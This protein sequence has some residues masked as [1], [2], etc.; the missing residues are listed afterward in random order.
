MERKRRRIASLGMHSR[1]RLKQQIIIHEIYAVYVTERPFP[2][3]RKNKKLSA[4]G[5]S[6]DQPRAVRRAQSKLGLQPLVFHTMTP[7][8]SHYHALCEEAKR[9][10]QWLSDNEKEIELKKSRLAQLQD[11][12]RSKGEISFAKLAIR[13]SAFPVFE[14]KNTFGNTVY[15]ARVIDVDD[16]FVTIRDDNCELG[17]RYR[18]SDGFLE[19]TRRNKWSTPLDIAKAVKIWEDH[20]KQ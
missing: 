20:K 9:I 17:K 1:K 19:R 2:Y 4:L 13:D 14:Q 16:K 3:T 18:R 6:P 10:K 7:E 8:E 12:W 15:C 11:G 5:A